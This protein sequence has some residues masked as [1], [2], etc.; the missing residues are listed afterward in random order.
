MSNRIIAIKT[1]GQIKI[2]EGQDCATL[3]DI[4]IGDGKEIHAFVQTGTEQDEKLFA[5]IT[6]PDKLAMYGYLMALPNLRGEDIN[7]TGVYNKLAVE[8][9]INFLCDLSMDMSVGTTPETNGQHYLKQLNN[10]G[11][12][13]Q[14]ACAIRNIAAGL[15]YMINCD[16]WQGGELHDF[17]IQR[18][19]E[20][21]QFRGY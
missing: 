7:K 6:D 19:K 9:I 16:S 8:A 2:P 5:E 10:A 15:Q 4:T 20:K 18:L 11:V 12:P 1:Y 13:V 21:L 14:M 17:D 3:K